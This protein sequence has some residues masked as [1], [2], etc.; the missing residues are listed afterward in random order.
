MVY[1][2]ECVTLV[3]S[4][5]GCRLTAYKDPAGV[6]TIGYGH[7]AGVKRN[8]RISQATANYFLAEDLR[9]AFLTVN[10]YYNT[11]HWTQNEVDAL[12]SFAFNTGNI[13]QLTA[14]GTRNK[15]VIANKM[16]EYCHAGGKKLPG[17]VARRQ[18]EH[19]LFVKSSNTTGFETYHNYIVNTPSGLNV[20]YGAGTQNKIKKVY[21]NGTKFTCL[22]IVPINNQIWLKTPSGY[23]CARIGNTT[24]VR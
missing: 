22:G 12:T 16:L 7:T 17:L 18:A 11:Y 5:E 3:K 4:F 13:D 19:D 6:Y 23:I 14:N 20:R 1:S 9:K 24:Y 21:P 8:Q 10:K 15:S 2:N